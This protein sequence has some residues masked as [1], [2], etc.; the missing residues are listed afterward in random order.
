M[1]RTK[2][3]RSVKPSIWNVPVATA[4][5]KLPAITPPTTAIP[6]L[7]V[8]PVKV[9]KY[10][11]LS[12]TGATKVMEPSGTGLN[13]SAPKMPVTAQ[14]ATAVRP[15]IRPATMLEG[16]RRKS[17]SLKQKTRNAGRDYH[18]RGGPRRIGRQAQQSAR[19]LADILI[20]E[21]VRLEVNVGCGFNLQTR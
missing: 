10:C 19:H 18:R 3:L 15:I 16:L 4:I 5:R 13:S 17:P 11:R 12:A 2:S 7:M 14:P 6:K 21:A 9:I 20:A 8:E 1:W